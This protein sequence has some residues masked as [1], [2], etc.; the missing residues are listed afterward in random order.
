VTRSARPSS[1]GELLSIP[2]VFRIYGHCK[3]GT[4]PWPIRLVATGSA[5]VGVSYRVGAGRPRRVL[6]NPGSTLTLRLVPGVFRSRQ[7]PDPV[8]HSPAQTI[9]T[10]LPV[11]LSVEE[12]SEPR[13][14][15]ENI[16]FVV[17]AALSDTADCAL[18]SSSVRGFTFYP[19]GQP[20]G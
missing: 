5:T 9:K 17:A 8:I 10:T 13:I 1:T 16:T 7:P 3:P 19:G 14:Y 4:S 12:G 20:A 2:A 11:S 15:R 6:I 18:V